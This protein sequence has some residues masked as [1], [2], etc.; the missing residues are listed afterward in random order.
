MTAVAQRMQEKDSPVTLNYLI[1]YSS[2]NISR[3]HCLKFTFLT[4]GAYICSEG[5]CSRLE[6]VCVC[7]SVRL[8]VTT[9]AETSLVSVLHACSMAGVVCVSRSVIAVFMS[10]VCSCSENAG[11]DSF[12]T[13]YISTLIVYRSNKYYS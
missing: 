11:N 10:G 8:S 6:C 9:L 13:I 1:V 12:V 2:T 4:L 7:V 3:T 5:Y